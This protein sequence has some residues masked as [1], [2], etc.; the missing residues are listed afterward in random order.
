MATVANAKYD[1]ATIED[2]SDTYWKLREE[3]KRD[4]FVAWYLMASVAYY[5]WNESWIPDEDY[6]MLCFELYQKFE[7][8][9]H[10]HKHLLDKEALLAGTGFHIKQYDYPL[11]TRRAA[12]RVL[13]PGDEACRNMPMNDPRAVG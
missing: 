9:N 7:E 4:V 8:L 2:R 1:M 5:H 11:M 10:P 6:D 12:W 13:N 3:G